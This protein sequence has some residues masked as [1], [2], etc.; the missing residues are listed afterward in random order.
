[1]SLPEHGRHKNSSNIKNASNTPL[2]SG[3]ILRK[4]DESNKQCV[5]HLTLHTPLVVK[6]YL[7]KKVSL[8]IESGGVT[9][10][11]FLSEVCDPC[12]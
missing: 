2:K 7:P 10:T 11:A 12:G 9:N 8:A 1:M 3:K 4:P 5:H 6:N